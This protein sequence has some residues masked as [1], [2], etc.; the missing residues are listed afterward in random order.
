MH[1]RTS[2]STSG[3][4]SSRVAPR[5]PFLADLF[6][7]HGA[8]GGRVVTVEH[9]VDPQHPLHPLLRQ[10]LVLYTCY[11]VFGGILLSALFLRNNSISVGISG[12]LLGMLGSIIYELLMD[13]PIYPN[14]KIYGVEG[15]KYIKEC[16]DN[17][18]LHLIGLLNDGGVDSWLDQLQLLLELDKSKL[19]SPEAYDGSVCLGFLF[20]GSVSLGFQQRLTNAPHQARQ[21]GRDRLKDM[22]VL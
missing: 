16:C 1:R 22:N 3:R 8:R 5:F 15:F 9:A 11:L 21:L 20:D 2:A 18:N 6:S 10:A 19:T 14:Q 7:N 17:D 12:A 4:S 13:W